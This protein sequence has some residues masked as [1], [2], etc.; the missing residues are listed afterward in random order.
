MDFTR[1]K[2]QDWVSALETVEQL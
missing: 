1:E 2:L